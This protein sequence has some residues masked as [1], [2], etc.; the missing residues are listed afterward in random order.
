MLHHT[1]KI[2]KIYENIQTRLYYM[3]PEKWEDLYLYSSVIEDEDGKQTGELYFY[4]IPRGILKK[5]PVNVYE[6][7]N[8][9][10][11]DENEYVEL[12]KKVYEEIKELREAF[13]DTG[14]DP[15]W[16]NLTISIEDLDF[17]VEYDYSDLKLSTFD[18]YERHIIW[19]YKYLGI[20]PEQVNNK[21]KQILNRYF[22][23][24]QYQKEKPKVDIYNATI[25]VRD[26]GNVVAFNTTEENEA[27]R[28]EEIEKEKIK[29]KIQLEVQPKKK[30][31][32][33]LLL[34]Q[35]EM[36]T[37]QKSKGN[38]KTGGK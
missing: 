36:E 33:Q 13:R 1:K 7:P 4:Y 27:R 31:K 19:R 26:F 17:K 15:L 20:G 29:Q 16:S 34:S 32:N 23:Q 22:A 18:S 8:K 10:N 3:I 25:Y 38:N 35:E 11:I 12:V 6:V 14:L 37:L 5:K 28:N 24:I 30:R 9:F 2:R 21:D